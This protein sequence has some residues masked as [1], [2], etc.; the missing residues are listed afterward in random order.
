MLHSGMPLLT[1]IP[2]VPVVSRLA[3]F[4]RSGVSFDAQPIVSGF[5]TM[6]VN[7]IGVASVLNSV[8]CS[9]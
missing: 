3:D 6:L 5:L 1:N 4:C 8:F 2:Q 9:Q 7:R